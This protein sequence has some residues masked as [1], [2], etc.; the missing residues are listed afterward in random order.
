MLY[1]TDLEKNNLNTYW[2]TKDDYQS[3]N[4]GVRTKLEAS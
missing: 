3:K 4:T 2:I 1:F